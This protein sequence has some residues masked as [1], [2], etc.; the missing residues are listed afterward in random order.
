VSYYRWNKREESKTRNQV[1]PVTVYARVNQ[2]IEEFNRDGSSHRQ[3]RAE[4]QKF[5]GDLTYSPPAEAMSR[6]ERLAYAQISLD[7]RRRK[8]VAEQLA[9]AAAAQNNR[10]ALVVVHPEGVN[11]D[12]DPGLKRLAEIL[13]KNDDRDLQHAK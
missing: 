3:L 1:E 7:M 5:Q 9:A 10:R 2:V 11:S 6:D 4:L 8:I 12:R 13:T